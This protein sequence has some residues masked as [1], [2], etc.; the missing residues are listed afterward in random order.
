MRTDEKIIC[1]MCKKDIISSMFSQTIVV[2]D[3]MLGDRVFPDVCADCG[4]AVSTFIT[5]LVVE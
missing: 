4:N 3:S 5:T 1:D 2:R